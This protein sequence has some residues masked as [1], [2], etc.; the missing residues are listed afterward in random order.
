MYLVASD[1]WNVNKV[2]LSL[3]DRGLSSLGSWWRLLEM[4]SRLGVILIS[5]HS[6]RHWKWKLSY[7]S[8]SDDGPWAPS[9]N[10][11]EINSMKMAI[12]YR[13]PRI[14]QTGQSWCV[15]QIVRNYDLNSGIKYWINMIWTSP[16]EFIFFKLE[17]YDT[18]LE[19]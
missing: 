18:S 6:S 10:A 17:N 8:L 4:Q 9:G 2:C 3:E 7:S 15:S 12:L 14:R 13:P 19:N 1:D 5:M 11:V 16:S